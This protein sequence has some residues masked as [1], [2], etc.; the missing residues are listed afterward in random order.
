MDY[1]NKILSFEERKVRVVGTNEDPWFCGNDVAIIL[2]YKDTRKSLKDHVDKEDTNILEKIYDGLGKSPSPILFT[3]NE[4]KTIYINESGLYSLILRS[5]LEKAKE[6]KRWI[7]SEVLPSI[8]KQGQYILKNQL[9]EKDE[10]LKIK[11][12]ELQKK[13]QL[14]NCL[15]IHKSIFD[16]AVKNTEKKEEVYIVTSRQYSQEYLFKIGTSCDSHKRLFS[17]NTSTIHENQ[18][19]IAHTVVCYD[20]KSVEKTVRQLLRRFVKDREFL[21]FPFDF[22]V[23]IVD[24]VAKGYED[25]NEEYNEIIDL[26]NDMLN[27]GSLKTLGPIPEPIT[28]NMALVSYDNIKKE[29]DLSKFSDEEIHERLQQCI[30]RYASRFF[31]QK[32]DKLIVYWIDLQPYIKDAFE[33]KIFKPLQWKEKVKELQGEKLKIMW[34]KRDK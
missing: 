22:L 25:F 7:T 19:Y 9:K 15:R 32:E 21:Y 14:V 33:L 18:L 23:R 13:E 24:S 26:Y 17:L 27:K 31:K 28:R 6:F 8:R 1:L 11:D 20:G 4:L 5:K 10:Q 12:E 34:R 2:G 29:I 16:N 30:D 3:Y